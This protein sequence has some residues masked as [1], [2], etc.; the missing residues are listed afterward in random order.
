MGVE[1]ERR[2]LVKDTSVLKGKNF[3]GILQG[4]VHIGEKSVSRVRL[5]D[6]KKAYFTVKGKKGSISRLEYEYEINVGDAK[7]MLEKICIKPLIV[8]KRYFLKQANFLW[9]IDVFEEENK[10]LVIAE[11]ELESENQPFEKPLWLGEEISEDERYYNYSLVL[12]PYKNWE[13]QTGE[14][15]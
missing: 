14:N 15:R 13:K 4:Y 2:F 10:G 5:I 8:K 3:V 9:E 12:N 1:I 11:I 6:N 7:E